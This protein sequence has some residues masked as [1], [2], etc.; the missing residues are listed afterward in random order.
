MKELLGNDTS[1]VVQLVEFVAMSPIVVVVQPIL[2][3]NEEMEPR[4]PHCPVPDDFS[5]RLQ[6]RCPPP[7]FEFGWDVQGA[8]S[9]GQF[10]G[11]PLGTCNRREL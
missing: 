7:V 6:L 5:P 4:L 11:S 9:H 1:L 10:I 2:Q 3:G 8:E